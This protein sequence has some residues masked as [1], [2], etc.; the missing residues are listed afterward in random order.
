M[1]CYYVIEGRKP[2]I[3]VVGKK[4][5]VCKIVDVTVP[6]DCKVNSRKVKKLRNIKISTGGYQRCGLCDK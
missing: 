6:T 2:A 3:M 5:R 1:Q 4:D